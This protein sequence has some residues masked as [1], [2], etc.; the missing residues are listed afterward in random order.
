[1]NTGNS[2]QEADERRVTTAYELSDPALSDP[3]MAD[4]VI[5]DAGRSGSVISDA[6]IS[7]AGISDAG[8]SDAGR[9]D[10]GLSDLDGGL[11]GR[12]T[13]AEATDKAAATGTGTQSPSRGRSTR[14]PPSF[15]H[16]RDIQELIDKLDAVTRQLRAPGHS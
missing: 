8:R 1:M 5:S 10:A 11:P 2:V 13:D 15:Q 16:V 3:V 14:T 7:D 12:E 4:A 9:S 6:G